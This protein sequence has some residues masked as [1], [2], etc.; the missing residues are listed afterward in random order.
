M[1]S[2]RW[3]KIWRDLFGNKGR[4]ILVI[5]S[6]SV[7]LIG[8]GAIGQAQHVLTQGM[9][10]SQAVS[11][12]P[13]GTM[14]IPSFDDRL[15]EEIRQLPHV[16]W[17]EGRTVI[18]ARISKAKQTPEASD[19]KNIDL[20]AIPDFA[21]VRM[22][23]ITRKTGEWPPTKG[24]LLLEH[25]SADYLDVNTG[26]FVSVETSD[27]KVHLLQ[28][29]GLV[30]DPGR[31][32]TTLSGIQYG[33]ISMDTLETLEQSNSFNMLSFTVK[34]KGKNIREIEEVAAGIRDAVK[35]QGY[36]VL[37]TRIPD[38]GKHWGYDIVTSMGN[39]L[40]TMGI[41]TLLLGA[42]L[43]INTVFANLAG[44]L[45]QIGVMK[46]LGA[47]PA[48]LIGMYLG[49]VL[50]FGV[51]SLLIGLPVSVLGAKALTNHSNVLLNFHSDGY[52]Y[53]LPI[54]LLQA[55]IALVLPLLAALYPVAKGTRISVREA[56]SYQGAGQPYG[57][58][59]TDKLLERVKGLPRPFLLSLRNTFRKKDRLIIT[60]F[61][62][63]LGGAI[64]IS[65]FSV[66]ASM[67][68]TLDHSLNY[69][70]YDVRITMSQSQPARELERIAW[71][72]PDVKK[73]EVWEMTNANR[74]RDDGSEST[75]FVIA[76]LPKGSSLVK[77]TLLKG[78]WLKPDDQNAL[79]ID[80]YL[81]GKEPDLDVGKTVTLKINGKET[82]WRVVGIARKV[83]GEVV[84]YV[85][86]S[87]LER[88]L[89]K[90]NSGS[91]LH[92]ITSR[93]DHQKQSEVENKVKS[94]LTDNGAEVSSSLIISEFRQVQEARINIVIV[95]L[96]LM[97]ILL[98]IVAGF[99]L[100][101]TL[102]LSVMER[103]QEIGIMRSIGASDAS[104]FGNVI[105]EGMIIGFISWIFGSLLA[106]P[107][108]RQICNALGKSLFQAPLDYTFPVSGVLFWLLM[109]IVLSIVASFIPAWNATRLSIRDV[110]AYE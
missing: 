12:V 104:I 85:D 98:T 17:A 35:K 89:D 71:R 29:S 2:P 48:N 63:S 4:T 24:N 90:Q 103:K 67:R 20:F 58:G 37:S 92:V 22:N 107:I 50:I 74:V 105:Y 32:S 13:S 5:L 47:T 94:L 45:R 23:K 3:Q 80:S 28:V 31:E 77:P 46:V 33:Y 88:A 75:D 79:V 18:H 66:Y 99:G 15:V 102:S 96:M 44:Q 53:S 49:L 100:T 38:P 8:V 1:I 64:V 69:A 43:V 76:G 40:Q 25:L 87:A 39:I 61:T 91:L 68:L 106:I 93:H 16:A 42:S 26:D 51:I 10:N 62:L 54:F 82:T 36:T 65:V 14:L 11:Q 108:S 72:V 59:W 6:I 52:G 60:L 30:T 81:L 95:F 34:G 83:V 73:V 109:V 56:I 41:L 70:K 101:G 9:M 97:A 27:G 21:S 78:R 86:Y 57:V 7:G 19:Q 84:S 55:V 110:L